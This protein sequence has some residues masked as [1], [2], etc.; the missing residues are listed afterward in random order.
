MRTE[1]KLT[2]EEVADLL[3]VI[4]E[5]RHDFRHAGGCNVG[6]VLFVLALA[7]LTVSRFGLP[8]HWDLISALDVI[9]KGAI[10]IFCLFLVRAIVISA[11]RERS[12]NRQFELEVVPKIWAAAEA[13]DAI[14]Y[15]VK[16]DEIILVEEPDEAMLYNY[17]DLGDGTTLYLPEVVSIAKGVWPAA[18]FEVVTSPH[19]P[20]WFIV[21][22]GDE[23]PA[24]VRTVS[25]EPVDDAGSP[26]PK[27]LAG[28]PEQALRRLGY[29]G[30]ITIRS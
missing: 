12:E 16:T 8:E 18:E 2:K 4:E 27:I 24:L 1:R 13:A 14:A 21:S 9:G 6:C 19:Y 10:A 20:S 15:K 28:T 23:A 17:I 22:A 26:E 29:K 7:A 11:T 30:P 3:G 25:V 5:R